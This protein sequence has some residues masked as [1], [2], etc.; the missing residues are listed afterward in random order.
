MDDSAVVCGFEPFRDLFRDR[1]RIVERN[2]PADQPFSEIL[3]VDQ[4][5]HER[6]DAAGV[7]QSVHGRDVRMI[8]GGENLRF[9]LKT[10]EPVGIG[11]HRGRED[12]DGDL[13][14]Q[15]GVVGAVH[16]AHAARPK[17]RQ[18]F[19]ATETGSRCKGH[20]RERRDH[21]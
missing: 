9:A 15:F 3:S 12:F 7:L 13:T 11:R 17:R 2:G 1:Q 20:L 4:F 21:T 8:Q 16:L 10:R 5:H 14:F 18:N 6:L 19:I